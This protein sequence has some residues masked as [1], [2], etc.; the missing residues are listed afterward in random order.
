M[1]PS[2]ATKIHTVVVATDFSEDSR[3]ALE[4]AIDVAR[5]RGARIVLTHAVALCSPVAPEF[6]PGEDHWYRAL[7]E[8]ALGELD[9]W[10]NHVR[11]KHVAVETHLTYEPAATSVVEVAARH[12]ADLLVIGTRG[13][14]GL[15][16]IFLG[17][18]AARIVRFATCPVVTVH[19]EQTRRGP[20]QTIL[21]PTDLS[22]DASRAVDA[23]ARVLGDAPQRRVIL[24]HVYRYPLVFSAAPAFVLAGEIVDLVREAR[25][26]LTQHAER[27]RERGITAE[28]VVEEGAPAES[29]LR[30]AERHGADLIAMGTHGRSGLNR[31]F[32]GSTAER[33]LPQAP[34][35]VLTV[36][37]PEP[38]PSSE[39]E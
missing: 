36:H 10:A 32:L 24:L 27:F 3:A 9:T 16:R 15:R 34:C 7:K 2:D 37:T 38:A 29:I 5:Q 28:V 18:V 1:S 25:A 14:T 13:L 4:W 22:D 26:Q 20:V 31:L 12:G 35:P 8:S 19:A 23:A 30:H 39:R 21:L 11:A 6:A 33:V 17:S